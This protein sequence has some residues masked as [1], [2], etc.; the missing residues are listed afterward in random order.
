TSGSTGK[1]KGVMIEHHSVVNLVLWVNN[2]FHI[3]DQDRLMFITSICFDLS[4]YD[5]FGILSSG[6]SIVIADQQEILDLS[7]LSV[8]LQTNKVTFWDS[9]PTTL[10]FLIR[11][12]ESAGNGH[13][14]TELRVVFLSGDWIPVHLPERIKQFFPNAVVI[15]LGGATEATVWPNFYPVDKIDPFWKS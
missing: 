10:D 7:G 5:I 11:G 12:L 6:G 4:V 9:V 8:L 1:P 13:L 3:D 14:Q 15:S 2:T